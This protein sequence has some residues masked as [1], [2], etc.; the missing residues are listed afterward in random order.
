MLLNCEKS[1]VFGNETKM[2]TL[3]S[4][5]RQEHSKLGK[6][7]TIWIG[8]AGLPVCYIENKVKIQKT[9]ILCVASKGLGL[10]SRFDERTQAEDDSTV[11]RA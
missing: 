8:V 4:R 3:N 9:I 11:V 5:R 7:S 2:S 1:L 6:C 10:I